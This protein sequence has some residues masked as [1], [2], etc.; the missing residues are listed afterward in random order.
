MDGAFSRTIVVIGA[1]SDISS[2]LRY[3]ASRRVEIDVNLGKL[4]P[5]NYAKGTF[6]SVGSAIIT[7]E[8]HCNSN[9]SMTSL[10]P[11]HIKI[12]LR[13]CL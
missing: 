11:L 4:R 5:L 2:R 6:I 12:Q 1:L 7:R 3:L 10:Y 13:V 8:E 9:Y